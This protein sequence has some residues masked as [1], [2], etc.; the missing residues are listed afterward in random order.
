M[1]GKLEKFSSLFFNPCHVCPSHLALPFGA[2]EAGC[3]GC[4]AR[5]R[6]LGVFCRSCPCSWHDAGSALIFCSISARKMSDVRSQRSPQLLCGSFRAAAL[7][8]RCADNEQH[9]SRN[10]GKRTKTIH[11]YIYMTLKTHLL[12]PSNGTVHRAGDIPVQG[13]W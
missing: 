12:A 1:E 11:I 8:S 4:W 5:W 13:W 10:W 2:G 6:L 9:R 3:T 7:T